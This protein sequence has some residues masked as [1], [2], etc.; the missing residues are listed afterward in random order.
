[1]KLLNIVNGEKF[2]FYLMR[3]ARAKGASLKFAQRD[4]SE[5][6]HDA[7]L[8]CALKLGADWLVN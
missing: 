8:R 1:M 4:T 5:P 2:P 3:R 6:R 7:T